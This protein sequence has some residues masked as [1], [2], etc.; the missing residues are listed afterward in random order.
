M[1][2][3][4]TLLLLII[5]F[6]AITVLV[7][8]TLLGFAATCPD[9]TPSTNEVT[10]VRS[11]ELVEPLT[12]APSTNFNPSW[13]ITPPRPQDMTS[14]PVPRYSTPSRIPRR[15]INRV[16]TVASSDSS[17]TSP[18]P[19]SGRTSVSLVEA[20]A[21]GD[22]ALVDKT[23]SREASL[24]QD[25]ANA[26]KRLES[27]EK[28]LEQSEGKTSKL[29]TKLQAGASD[30]QAKKR[31]EQ[32]LLDSRRVEDK[33]VAEKVNLQNDIR[34]L[35]SEVARLKMDASRLQNVQ[36]EARRQVQCRRLALR[37]ASEAVSVLAQYELIRMTKDWE[38]EK[39]GWIQR[40]EELQRIVAHEKHRAD[41]QS[42]R[43]ESLEADYTMLMKRCSE[44]DAMIQKMNVQIEVA[45]QERKVFKNESK[46]LRNEVLKLTKEI[47]KQAGSILA[48]R[49]RPQELGGGHH[50]PSS[51][52]FSHLAVAPEP[53]FVSNPQAS[54]YYR[55]EAPV[56]DFVG[57]FAPAHSQPLH[58]NFSAEEPIAGFVSSFNAGSSQPVHDNVQ[59]EQPVYDFVSAFNG[60][61]CQPP[62][63]PVVPIADNPFMKAPSGEDFVEN[64][65][66]EAPANAFAA[67]PSS[68][69]Q[70]DT[71]PAV[72]TF[73]ATPPAAVAA[74]SSVP[75]PLPFSSFGQPATTLPVFDTP[76]NDWTKVEPQPESK[77][78]RLQRALERMKQNSEAVCY[79]KQSDR[80]ARNAKR[81]GKR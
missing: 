8:V 67:G 37:L 9:N 79:G 62:R 19:P 81:M 23:T 54:D 57:S 18:S 10:T 43:R 72:N 30:L 21:A 45:N 65:V 80:R 60:D 58:H 42:S 32:Q 28:R 56:T 61:L 7:G 35:E 20:D 24:E 17:D 66:L 52:G 68:E 2:S 5:C 3:L 46:S 27:T 51:F 1:L 64:N 59:A 76:G 78:E 39:Q 44:Q 53:M 38:K 74:P 15:R 71:R 41:V 13:S 26:L 34:R 48:L 55:V 70:H 36:R 47:A 40:S 31:F 29:R 77:E 12:A 69:A 75:A 25:L 11:N 4:G 33:H 50:Q 63:P 73:F 16:S 49:A 22:G 14:R 6:I